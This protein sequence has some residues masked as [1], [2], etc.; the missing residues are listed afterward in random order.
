MPVCTTRIV[1]PEAAAASEAAASEA[2]ASEAAAA[3]AAA[4]AAP[5]RPNLLF[6]MIDPI[7]RLQFSQQ[8]PD[9]DRL[10]ASSGFSAFDGYGAVGDNSGP[11]QVAM[12]LGERL[13]T[14]SVASLRNR[15]WLWD[16]LRQAGYATLKAEDGCVLNSNMIASMRPRTT[17]GA[18][19]ERLF[20]YAFDEPNCLGDKCARAP[21]TGAVACAAPPP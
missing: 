19:L 4:A 18:Q 7:S 11:N 20:C 16:A 21:A 17:H 14:R 12:F 1:R 3:E 5:A 10:L 13:G 8:L 9:L 2:A 6:V 15:T